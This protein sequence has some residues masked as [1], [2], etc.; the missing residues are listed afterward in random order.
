M[1][2]DLK[3]EEPCHADWGEM[4][5]DARKRHCGEC[6]LDVYN[7]SEMTQREMD[8]VLE[9][10]KKRA[11]TG[12]GARLCVRYVQREDGSI[13]TKQCATGFRA[14]LLRAVRWTG[15]MVAALIS[16]VAG[17]PRGA[18][19][20]ALRTEMAQAQSTTGRAAPPV[21]LVQIQG[22]PPLV[23]NQPATRANVIEVVDPT[24]GYVPNAIITL[25]SEK[26]A[27]STTLHTDKNGVAKLDE[28][29]EGNYQI[30]VASLGFVTE[31]RNNV[32]LPMRAAMRVELR[33]AN[34]MGTVMLTATE[35]GTN[36]T[37]TVPRKLEKTKRTPV[38]DSAVVLTGPDGKAMAFFQIR[39]VNN[40]TGKAIWFSTDEYGIARI[41]ELPSGDYRIEFGQGTTIEDLSHV[42]FPSATAVRA[43]LQYSATM[44]AITV[45]RGLD[46]NTGKPVQ[47]LEKP[48]D[49]QVKAALR[50]EAEQPVAPEID[51]DAEMMT[52]MGMTSLALSV[53]GF[54]GQPVG[55]TVVVTN[56]ET[57]AQATGTADAQGQIRF[58]GLA[59][60]M[61]TISV[62]APNRQPTVLH[63]RLP[64]KLMVEA[65]M[66]G[67]MD[68]N[69]KPQMGAV[70]MW[71]RTKKG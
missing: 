28:L 70:V 10:A 54:G 31:T 44:G 63:Q 64:S 35:S 15:A 17:V 48:V 6:R 59:E 52:P 53:R 47:T 33:V 45:G 27:A 68:P 39:V 61:Y 13:I 67:P 23:Q 12:A 7:F 41:H 2:H 66:S 57:H 69:A 60:G 29:P 34:F 24:G 30:K 43:T 21:T 22:A 26:T 25:V 55:V 4:A 71:K 18:K 46:P 14:N 1:K 51:P 32:S 20:A 9:R 42:K 3:I 58:V 62:S 50:Q 49:A 8:R 56:D 40:D 65:M 19:A 38:R 16:F 5:G 37:N 36:T 11:A